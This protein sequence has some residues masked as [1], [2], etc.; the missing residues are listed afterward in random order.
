[1]EGVHSVIFSWEASRPPI[2]AIVLG[3]PGRQGRLEFLLFAGQAIRVFMSGL[4]YIASAI[5]LNAHCGSGSSRRILRLHFPPPPASAET[6]PQSSILRPGRSYSDNSG[7]QDPRK[8]SPFGR[9]VDMVRRTM[10][11]EAEIMHGPRFQDAQPV[12]LYVETM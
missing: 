4:F 2:R 11:P 3:G 6:A 7:C 12:A 10:A 8:G 1:M 5:D 9:G